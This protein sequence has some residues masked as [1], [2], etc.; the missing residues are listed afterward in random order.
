MQESCVSL[1]RLEHKTPGRQFSFSFQGYFF[2][3]YLKPQSLT[4]L[5]KWEFLTASGPHLR[6]SH[7]YLCQHP[8]NFRSSNRLP[9][10]ISFLHQAPV[11]NSTNP[12]STSIECEKMPHLLRLFNG[13]RNPHFHKAAQTGQGRLAFCPCEW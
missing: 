10:F 7:L 13:Y 12:D 9:R 2:S 5:L 8:G 3:G 11:L 4:T 6:R 1:Q